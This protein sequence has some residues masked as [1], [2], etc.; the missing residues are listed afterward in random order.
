[1]TS[2]S[3]D[4]S[5]THLPQPGICCSKV[6]YHGFQSWI[7]LFYVAGLRFSPALLCSFDTASAWH[8]T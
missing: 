6:A 2:N 3:G 8:Y 5:S 7:G 4:G 1:M